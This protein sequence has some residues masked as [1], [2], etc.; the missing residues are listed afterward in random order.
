MTP[1]ARF[2]RPALIAAA[3]CLLAAA[4]TAAA[5]VIERPIPRLCAP[6]GPCALYPRRLVIPAEALGRIGTIERDM[7][8]LRWNGAGRSGV[9][10]FTIPRPLDY[11]GGPI[12]VVLFHHVPGDA[13]GTIGFA[14]TTVNVK[15]GGPYETYGGNATALIPAHADT[16][17]EQW[18]P[19]APEGGGF[20]GAGAW[21]SVEIS[22]LGTFAD[23]TVLLTV[24]VE[25]N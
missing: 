19:L 21:W 7:R 17:Y 25:Y 15:A 14:L 13:E 20:S 5:P 3:A 9:T 1:I 24:L 16:H 22:R 6:V 4:P 8:G 12:R 10:S 2:T 23:P 18:A 11:K